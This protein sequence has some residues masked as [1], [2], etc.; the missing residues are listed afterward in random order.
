[1]VR[2][3]QDLMWHDAGA[4]VWSKPSHPQEQIQVFPDGWLHKAWG[5]MKGSGSTVRELQE[6]LDKAGLG[7]TEPHDS[8]KPHAAYLKARIALWKAHEKR[9]D[10][11]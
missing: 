11:S 8:P 5:E 4:G 9:P 7:E 2:H 3:M 6:Y 1:M 10:P